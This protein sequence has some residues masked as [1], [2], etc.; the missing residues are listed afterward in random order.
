MSKLLSETCSN[1][2]T[3]SSQRM[4]LNSLSSLYRVQ[5]TLS[6]LKEEGRL[7]SASGPHGSYFLNLMTHFLCSLN[8]AVNFVSCVSDSPFCVRAGIFLSP[9]SKAGCS[10]SVSFILVKQISLQFSS[11]VSSFTVP[12]G[13]KNKTVSLCRGLG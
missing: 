8:T 3:G 10:E 5:K 11:R 13:Q 1:E 9:F 7:P 6:H 12:L 4:G 2:N